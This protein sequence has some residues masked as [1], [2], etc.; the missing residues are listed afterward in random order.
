M[1]QVIGM[2]MG[3]IHEDIQRSWTV[4]DWMKTTKY[5][6]TRS[7]RARILRLARSKKY[8]VFMARRYFVIFRPR[9]AHP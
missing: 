4:D 1:A 2:K 3:H 6:V 9:A 7:S 8:F 5:H